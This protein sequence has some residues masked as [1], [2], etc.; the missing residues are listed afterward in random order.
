MNNGDL[1]MT[2]ADLP[3]TNADLPM[4]NGDLHMTNGDLSKFQASSRAP[5]RSAPVPWHPAAL[6]RRGD[7]N[8]PAAAG[9]CPR[10]R[11]LGERCFLLNQTYTFIY[12]Y[13][14]SIHTYIYVYT[15]I[16]IY[17]YFY[18]HIIYIYI[19]IQIYMYTYIIVIILGDVSRQKNGKIMGHI[20]GIIP[21]KNAMRI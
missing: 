3:M 7:R 2:N 14:Y 5:A 15:Y 4:K 10:C 21:R 9:R 6:R 1:P 11:N 17:T 16:Y 19:Y 20:M 18:I 13:I 8:D 12:I